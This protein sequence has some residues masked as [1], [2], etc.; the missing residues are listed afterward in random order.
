M[1]EF[2]QINFDSW[3]IANSEIVYKCF[4]LANISNR[5][6]WWKIFIY[7]LLSIF[8]C[9]DFRILLDLKHAFERS[10]AN[11]DSVC[12]LVLHFVINFQELFRSILHCLFDFKFI[13]LQFLSGLLQFTIYIWFV[14]ENFMQRIKLMMHAIFH[15][16]WS[17]DVWQNNHRDVHEMCVARYFFSTG[18]LNDYVCVR[19]LEKQNGSGDAETTH[20]YLI[21]N[22]W[23]KLL[24]GH[25][26]NFIFF[27]LQHVWQTDW[28]IYV[29]VVRSFE[30]CDCWRNKLFA[31][32]IV[33]TSQL[34][35]QIWMNFKISNYFHNTNFLN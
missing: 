27:G 28:W 1:F 15:E 20:C 5:M 17:N 23:I 9:L 32:R 6:K 14:F 4:V 25:H 34:I 31:E 24:H 7:V 22:W 30:I 26:N 29:V 19:S 2:L 21:F 18:L 8:S 35:Y 16:R 13:I 10:I 11:L 33:V 3:N 12:T